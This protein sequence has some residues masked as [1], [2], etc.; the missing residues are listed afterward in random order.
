MTDAADRLAA[1]R[2]KRAARAASQ[3]ER[4]DCQKA[5][6]LEAIDALEDAQDYHGVRVLDID[7]VDG[8]PCTIAVRTP[9]AC[10][11]KRYH[12]RLRVKT[13]RGAAEAPDGIGAQSELGSACI[14]YPT[15]DVLAQLVAIRSGIPVSA[16]MAAVEL[17]QARDADEGKG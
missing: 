7:Y 4:E 16:G 10:E 2:A 13:R 3:Q 17:A 12:D 9:K 15:G 8:L 6:D 1:I 5:T 14:I 11:V